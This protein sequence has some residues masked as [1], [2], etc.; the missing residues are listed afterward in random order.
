MHR[1][2]AVTARPWPGTVAVYRSPTDDNFQLSTI[3]A[4]RSTIGITET[5]L[6]PARAGF[7]DRGDAL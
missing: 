5:A 2:I 6:P 1:N 7:W 4:A 3:I